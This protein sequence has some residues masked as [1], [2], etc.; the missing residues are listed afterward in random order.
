[1]DFHY[2]LS[3]QGVLEAKK[4]IPISVPRIQSSGLTIAYLAKEGSRVRKGDVVVIL[5][6][7]DLETQV[8]N[9]S[10]ELEIAKAEKIQREAELEIEKTNLETEIKN[11][12]NRIEASR[13]KSEKM[14]F[15]PPN[16]IMIEKLQIDKL[17]IQAKT[18]R[19]KLN[20]LKK[21]H[22][23][24]TTRLNLKIRQAANIL[25]KTKDDLASWSMK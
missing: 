1:M 16:L 24:E 23:E 12:S 17:M 8:L 14:Q 22:Q 5:E 21:I 6:C 19:E 15:E 25:D 9:V 3:A 18:I 10:D 11:V 20:Y 4:S 7:T 2:Q 13:L